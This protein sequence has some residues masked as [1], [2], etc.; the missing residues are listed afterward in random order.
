M[1]LFGTVKPTRADIEANEAIFDQVERGQG[2]YIVV[3]ENDE[4]SQVYFAGYSYD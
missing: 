4:A 3:Y 2:V 1:D